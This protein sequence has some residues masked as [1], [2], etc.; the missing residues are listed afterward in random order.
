MTLLTE[1]ELEERSKPG[2]AWKNPYF[3]SVY[4]ALWT[5]LD[6]HDNPALKRMIETH[7]DD[8]MCKYRDTTCWTEE[9]WKRDTIAFNAYNDPE[10]F[11]GKTL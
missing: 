7:L 11:L 10:G 4:E 5:V 6:E 2:T 9:D 8:L 1:K 3:L